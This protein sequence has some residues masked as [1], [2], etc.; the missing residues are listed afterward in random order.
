MPIISK[1]HVSKLNAFKRTTAI[2][3]IRAMRKRIR[4]IPGGTSAGKTYGILPVLI[5]R[6]IKT[7]G[8]E[9]SVVSETMPHLKKGAIKD[10]IKIMKQTGRWKRSHWHETDKKYTFHNG[11]YIEFFSVDDE[12]KVRGPRRNVLYVNE[13]NNIKWETFYQLLIRTD[14]EIYIDYNPVSEFWVHTEIIP[15]KNAEVLTLTYKDNDALAR[16]IVKELE[17]N[18]Y[19]AY[20]NVKGDY[21]DPKNIK[22]PYWANWCKVYLR[23]EVGGLQGA[24]YSNWTQVDEIPA[25]A[26]L[27]GYGMDF[28][29][30]NDPTALVAVWYYDGEYYLDEV[31]YRTGLKSGQL[32]QMMESLGVSKYQNIFCDAAEPRLRDEIREYGFSIRGAVKGADSI[33]VGIDILQGVK[34]NVTKRSTNLITEFRNYVWAKDKQGKETNEP[35]DD[36]NHGMDAMRYFGVMRIGKRKRADDDVGVSYSR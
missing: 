16:T 3:K 20:Y 34:L 29:Y 2:N 23:G 36:Y 25:G 22:D 32:C 5:N 1:Q 7:D 4:V 30:T 27:L 21:D 28:G 17:S 10:F 12:A 15:K 24:I 33:N 8:I 9:I 35:I 18:L 6:A 14:R 13:A 31:I 19:K 11:S 26:S